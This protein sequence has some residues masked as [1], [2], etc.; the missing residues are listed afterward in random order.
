MLQT[1]RLTKKREDCA[2]S[3]EIKNVELNIKT[4]KDATVDL[5][6]SSGDQYSISEQLQRVNER[7][8]R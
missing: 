7:D 6:S 1:S 2:S 8:G 5:R 3:S 4:R